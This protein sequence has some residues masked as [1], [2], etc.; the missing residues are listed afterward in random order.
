MRTVA[1]PNLSLEKRPYRIL[2]YIH[3]YQGIH[4]RPPSLRDIGRHVNITSTSV[5]SYHLD[6][7]HRNGL[8]DREPLISRAI[9]ITEAGLKILGI[10][11]KECPTCHQPTYQ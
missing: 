4:R 7:L 5:V 2:A 3:E 8:I 6:Q 11:I 9:I 1:P 10:T